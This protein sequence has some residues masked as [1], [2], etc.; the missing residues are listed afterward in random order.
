[1]LPWILLGGL[2]AAAA[3]VII[4]EFA[5]SGTLFASDPVVLAAGLAAWGILVAITLAG[6]YRDRISPALRDAAIW[7]VIVAVVGLVALVLR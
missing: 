7:V 5:F 2:G 4:N 1:M 3:A 6:L